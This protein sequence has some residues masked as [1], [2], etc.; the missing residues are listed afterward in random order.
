MEIRQL[1]ALLGIADHGSFSDAATALSTVQSNISTRIA[2]L[3]TE[4]GAEL[5]DRSSAKLTESGMIVSERA[6][7][8][9]AEVGA[10]TSDVS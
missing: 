2:K 10:I 5:V 9:I 8:V 6:R 7:R 1:E 3:E 4:L